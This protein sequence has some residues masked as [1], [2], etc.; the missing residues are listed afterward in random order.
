MK[1]FS[2]RMLAL[3]GI[4]LGGIVVGMAWSIINTALSSIQKDLSASLLQL[5]WVMN[6]FGIFICVPMLAMGKLGDGWGRKKL[7]LIGICGCGSASLIAGLATHINT[8]IASQALFGLSAA[9]IIPISQALTVHQFPENKKE[10]AVGIWGTFMS[11]SLAIGPLVGGALVHFLSWRWVFLINLPLVGLAFILVLFAVK[12]EKPEKAECNWKAIALLMGVVSALVVAIVQAPHWG[13]SSTPILGLFL[14][15][16]FSLYLFKKEEKYAEKPLFRAEFFAQ[17]SFLFSAVG[18]A[19]MMGFIWATFFFIPLYL[20]NAFN[21]SPLNAG[22]T[23]LCI[24]IPVALFSMSVSKLYRKLGAKP[25]MLSGFFLL[26]LGAGVQALY[27]EHNS[28]ELIALSCLFIGLGWVLCWGPSTSFA[29]SSIPHRA[30]GIAS[31]MF[32]TLQEFGGNIGLALAGVFFRSGNTRVLEPHQPEI[33][34]ALLA[35]PQ[36]LA[37]SLLANP[38]SAES[39]LVKTSPILAWIQEAFISGYSSTM[40]FL[41]AFALFG[42]YL[43]GMVTKKALTK[44]L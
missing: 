42:I 21:Y 16:L 2:Q 36:E 8:I 11:I 24:S 15:A 19:C 13:W 40:W 9:A 43:S 35:L 7:Y 29:L 23:M 12:K 3:T 5:Q 17:P 28:Q 22:L 10:K 14:A 41:V 26:S 25:L 30:A 34:S 39:I 37:Q 32:T 20:Q 27:A 6:I 31:G 4:L 33:N 1:I 18:N 44:K 38:A